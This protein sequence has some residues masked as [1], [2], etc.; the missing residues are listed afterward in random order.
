MIRA[1]ARVLFELGEEHW[2]GATPDRYMTHRAMRG[3]KEQDYFATWGS[4][5][6]TANLSL[7]SLHGHQ[8]MLHPAPANLSCAIFANDSRQESLH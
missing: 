6:P 4:M 7:H 8:P 3:V 2:H 1:G 5:L